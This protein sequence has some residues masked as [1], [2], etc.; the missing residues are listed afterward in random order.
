MSSVQAIPLGF[1]SRGYGTHSTPSL[2]K[3]SLMHGETGRIGKMGLREPTYRTDAIQDIDVKSLVDMGIRCVLVDRDNTCVPRGADDAPDEVVEWF[4]RLR[5]AGI[6]PCIVSNNFRDSHIAR[7]AD[8]LGCG[9]V[10]LAWKPFPLALHNVLRILRF[11]AS[12]TVMIGDQCY[13]D[14]VAGNLMGM[15]TIL[16]S[17]QA[18]D[19]EPRY[20]RLMRRLFDRHRDVR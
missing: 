17:P 9:F 10:S 20:T 14:I 16:V 1:P 15:T 12:E 18:P 4:G 13:T 11:K 5:D 8:Q 3:L 6:T 2:S 7:T 19:A